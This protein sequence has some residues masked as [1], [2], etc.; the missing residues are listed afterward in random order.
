MQLSSKIIY[1][2]ENDILWESRYFAQRADSTLGIIIPWKLYPEVSMNLCIQ[3]HLREGD[4][5]MYFYAEMMNY[6]EIP[7]MWLKWRLLQ[8]NHF[9]DPL[10]R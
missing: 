5:N 1:S 4:E 9:S 3:K 8:E 7:T 2:I 6:D 10:A